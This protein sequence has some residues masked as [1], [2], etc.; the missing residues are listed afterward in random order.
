MSCA[1]TCSW[2]GPEGCGQDDA[3]V[4]CKLRTGNSKAK[5]TSFKLAAPTDKAGFPCSNPNVYL[6]PDLRKPLG[7]LTEFGVNK[8]VLYQESQIALTH[9][10][11]QV[12]QGS[13]L[14]CTP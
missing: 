8:P 9:G 13:S 3:D 2:A 12:I 11:A 10:T 5:A 14:I 6:E 7:L 1:K 4:F